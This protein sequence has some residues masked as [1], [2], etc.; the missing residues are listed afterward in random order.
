MG[1]TAGRAYSSDAISFLIVGFELF[2]TSL[3]EETRSWALQF[4]WPVL[5]CEPLPSEGHQWARNE[6]GAIDG[7]VLDLPSMHTVNRT[8]TPHELASFDKLWKE[9]G[10]VA[11]TL[12]DSQLRA[13][14]KQLEGIVGLEK[15][16]ES[17]RAGRCEAHEGCLG[18]SAD[19]DCVCKRYM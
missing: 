6:L 3:G 1:S 9:V 19:G 12:S 18:I 5:W 17:L 7:R 16:V 14:W 2:G 4:G 13:F 15:R 8:A 10:S 11:G